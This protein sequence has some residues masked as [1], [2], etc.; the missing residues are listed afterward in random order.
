MASWVREGLHLEDGHAAHVDRVDV[1]GARPRPVGR[2]L[3]VERAGRALLAEGLDLFHDERGLGLDGEELVEARAHGVD[4]LVGALHVGLLPLRGRR[5]V[6]FRV[7]LDVLEKGL[8]RRGRT[9][10]GP[11]LENR[12]AA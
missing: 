6:I 12:P 5:V 11:G 10:R 8:Q 3:L 4:D 2:G 1:I 7:L 9:R